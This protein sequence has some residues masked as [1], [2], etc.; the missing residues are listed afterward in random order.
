MALIPITYAYDFSSV[1]STGQTLY[2]GISGTTAY[3]TFAGNYNAPYS[4]YSKSTG[5]L[6]IPSSVTYNGNTYT[7]TRI[8]AS[9]FDGCSGLTSVTIPNSVTVIGHSA[10]SSCSGLTSVTIPNSV[11][12]IDCLAFSSC[13]GLTSVNYTGTIAQWCDIDFCGSESNPAF[14]SHTLNISGSPLTNLVV[15]EGVTEIKQYA[16]I[17]CSGLTSA[18]IPNS[19]TSIGRSAFSSCSGLTTVNFNAT[20]CTTMGDLMYPVFNGCTNIATLIIGEN[21]TQIPN[22]A[23]LYCSGLTSVTIPN[24]VTSIGS[25]AFDGCSGLTEIT[26]MSSVAP[27]LGSYAFSAVSTTIPINIPCGSSMSYYSRWNYF[28]NFYRI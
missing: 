26:S 1:A 28:S 22:V 25:R 5:N 4:G 17:S 16:F 27:L 19:V 2:Y 12:S 20:N 24:S 8:G 10:F 18:T 21:V 23:F 13:S 6:T 14:Y 9:A 3:V 7:V 15:P 11:T